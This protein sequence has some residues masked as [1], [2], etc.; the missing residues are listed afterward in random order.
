[1][2]K[3][4]F[5]VRAKDFEVLIVCKTPRS[6]ST[7]GST[8]L[9]RCSALLAVPDPALIGQFAEE[10]TMLDL[11]RVAWGIRYD[12]WSLVLQ[13]WEVAENCEKTLVKD[14][15][16]RCRGDPQT[17]P[18]ASPRQRKTSKTRSFRKAQC[19]VHRTIECWAHGLWLRRSVHFT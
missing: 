3:P 12:M 5:L 6:S 17:W 10:G 4:C 15:G 7:V 16:G 14:E 1:M 11:I 18:M 19:S 2:L 8:H 9:L 13:A